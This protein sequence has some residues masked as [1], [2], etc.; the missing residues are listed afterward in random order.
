MVELKPRECRKGYDETAE[1][2]FA[3]IFYRHL[4]DSK[5]STKYNGEIIV[6][7]PKLI[8]PTVKTIRNSRN[9]NWAEVEVSAVRSSTIIEYWDSPHNREGEVEASF[10]E[11][12]YLWGIVAPCGENE[13]IDPDLRR[14]VP[15][16]EEA[17]GFSF[18][19]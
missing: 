4:I 10:G 3:T 17:L 9:D 12:S 14:S 6:Q 11:T 2:R 16:L 8:I 5:F 1:H 7:I 15:Q 19:P 13:A 18:I